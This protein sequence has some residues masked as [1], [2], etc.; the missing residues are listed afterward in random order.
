[1]REDRGRIEARKSRSHEPEGA[2]FN[3]ADKA[4]AAARASGKKT[5]IEPSKTEKNKPSNNN[6][7]II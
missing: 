2:A 5:I 7:K 4:I 6:K 1:L 3:P